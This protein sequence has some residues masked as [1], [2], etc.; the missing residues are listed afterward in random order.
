MKS[1]FSQFLKSSLFNYAQRLV[2]VCVYLL[3][4]NANANAWSED[5]YAKISVSI[6]G[7]GVVY[8]KGPKDNEYKSLG[9]DGT[10][11]LKY[12]DSGMS[13]SAPDSKSI[14]YELKA[15]PIDDT[16]FFESWE[17]LGAANPI[18]L[19]VTGKTIENPTDI[20]S[21]I[22]AIFKKK[23]IHRDY[24]KVV[25]IYLDADGKVVYTGD[26]ANPSSIQFT[27]GGGYVNIGAVVGTTTYT[28]FTSGDDTIVY[29]NAS[30]HP[31]F[32]IYYA[33]A[34]PNYAFAG[35]Y[36]ETT[37]MAQLKANLGKLDLKNPTGK[38]NS[39]AADNEY[40]QKNT[41]ECP[42]DAALA[43]VAPTMYAVFR[44]DM[45]YYYTGPTAYVSAHE[46]D[47]GLV[48]VDRGD[49][50]SIAGVPAESWTTE[51]V[52]ETQYNQKNDKYSFVYYAKPNPKYAF[53]GW[54]TTQFGS[55]T[56]GNELPNEPY[57][58]PY[59][60]SDENANPE[61]PFITRAL[62][63]VFE[64]FYYKK[65]AAMLASNS[66]DAGYIYVS[67]T[68]EAMPEDWTED[69]Q[70]V[71]DEL[72]QVAANGEEYS[73]KVYYHARPK[74]G[75]TFSGWSSTSDGL[76]IVSQSADY[77]ET[78]TTQ[79]TDRAYPHVAAPLYAVFRSD[80]DIRQQ[81]RMIVYQDAEGNRSINDAKILVD[82]QKAAT[83]TATLSGDNVSDFILSNR[84]GSKTGQSITF[85]ATQGLIEM[86]LSYR[87]NLNEAVGKSVVVT[88][89]NAQLGI[90]RR[91][92][93]VVEE[94]PLITFLPTDG[95]GTYTVR[96][97]NG[98]G[99]NYI[100]NADDR[101]NLD[102]AVTHESMSNI[103]INLT[104]DVASDNYYFFGWEMIDGESRTYISHDALCTYQFT[105]SVKIRPDFI[106]NNRATFF[107]LS[108][109]DNPDKTLYHDL[110]KALNAAQQNLSLGGEQVVVLN[111]QNG[112]GTEVVLPKGNYEIPQGVILLIPGDATYTNK[113][114]LD[115]N[116]YE[117]AKNPGKNDLHNSRYYIKLNVEDGTK[118]TV[119]GGLNVYA[120]LQ[121]NGQTWLGR[122]W[123][124]GWID[125]GDN[126]TIDVESSA[127]LSVYGYITGPLSNAITIKPGATVRESFQIRDWH[128]GT[129]T[130][131]YVTG[132]STY[133]VF[134]ASQFY[135][136][137]IEVPLTLESG[138]NEELMAA[139]NIGA[140]SVVK[141]PFV[142]LQDGL[143]HLNTGTKLTK[144]YD[145]Y[146]DSQVYIME[147]SGATTQVELGKI[148]LQDVA[149][150]MPIIGTIKQDI[151]SS[152]YVLPLPHNMDITVKNAKLLVSYDFAFLAGSKLTID[153]TATVVLN[154][155]SSQA[156]N[157][158]VYDRA[159]NGN[160]FGISNSQLIPVGYRPTTT[161]NV[162][163]DNG[164]LYNRN[165]DA[166]QDASVV[167]DGLITCGQYGY[168][169]TTN[170]ANEV[171]HCA[172][173]TSNGGGKITFAALGTKS[174]TYQ[175]PMGSW[176]EIPVTPARMRNADG[177]YVA[178][179]AST[180]YTYAQN[181]WQTGDITGTHAAPTVAD[182]TPKFNVVVATIANTYVGKST[183]VDITIETQN[184]TIT[185]ADV[186]WTK[187]ISG[188]DA[189]Q[190]SLVENDSKIS[191]SPK[192]EGTKQVTLTLTATYTRY[193]DTNNPA[194]KY[195]YSKNIT[196]A[197][198][199][200]YLNANILAFE[201]L[202]SLY[203]GQEAIA[204][205]KDGN[206]SQPITIETSSAGIVT[207]S[208][209]T[210]AATL[211][212]TAVGEVT[213]TAIQ[214]A[215]LE[216]NIA[217]T[218]I[219]KRVK[220]TDPV[221]WNWD[222][223]YFGTVN[224]NPVTVLNG[225]S[226]W[227]LTEKE[228]T[229]NIIDFKTNPY[230]ATIAD[231][232]AGKYEV[233]FE[234]TNGTITKEFKS[235]V[236]VNPQHLRVDVNKDTVFHAVTLSANES[237]SFDNDNK[238]V[239][240]QSTEQSISQ[241]KMTFIGVPDKLYFI[242]VGENTWQIEEST[243]GVN[244][245]T[246]FPWKYLTANEPFEM[247]LLPS[248]KYVRISYGA[249][250]TTAALLK[251]LYIT[252]LEDVKADVKKIYMPID[253]KNN[254]VKEV[255]LT[256]AN[257]GR[258]DIRTNDASKFKIKFSDSNSE[259][260]DV[261]SI[262]ATTDEN[263][264]GIKG[265]EVV[266]YATEVTTG[267]LQ[268]YSGSQ[269]V[270]QIPIHAYLFP[271]ELPIKLA[272]DEP[273]GG[274]RYYYVTTHSH[275]VEWDGT[276]GVRKITMHNAVS[277]AA[278][279]VTF[280][281]EG[282]PTFISFD[283]TAAAKGT[284]VIEQSTDGKNWNTAV[285]ATGDVM[286]NGKLL[287]TVGSTSKYIRVIYESAY[288]EKVEITDLTIVGSA[289]V[290]VNPTKLQLDANEVD[291]ITLTAVNLTNVKIEP[292]G[293]F[294]VCL[295]EGGDYAGELS[296]T[297][298]NGLSANGIAY[299]TLYVK[300][301]GESLPMVEY[302]DIVITNTAEGA[303][304][305][306]LATVELVGIKGSITSGSLGINTGVPSGYT[307]KGTFEGSGY[308]NVNIS[309]AFSAGET[310]TP[311][312]DY[313]VIY[314]ETTTND[315]QSIITTPNKNAGSNAKT[316]YYIYKK[317]SAGSAYEL[318]KLVENANSANKAWSEAGDD[319]VRVVANNAVSMYI[320]GFC[321][322]ATT[323]YTKADEGVWYFRANGGQSIDVYLQDCYIYSRA[324]TFDGH[325]FADRQDGNSFVDAYVCGSG[326]VL[327]FACNNKDNET[328]MNVTI[329]TL[330]NNLLKSNYG[331]FFQSIAGRAFQASSPVQ[332]RLI[333]DTYWAATKT[334]LNF[335]DVWPASQ[336][337]KTGVRTN[338]FISL[339]KQVN[340]APSIDMGAPNTVVNFN[341]GQVE[342]QNAQIVSHNYKSSLAICPRSGE[343]A[344]I[345][346]SYGMATDATSGTV[347]FNDGTTTVQPMWVSPDYF[348]SY[349]CD[350]DEAGNYIRNAKGEY[351]T[352]CLRTPENTFVYGG[353]H[354]MMR[355][356]P[357][358]EAQGGAP[359]DKPGEDGKLL[360][361]YKYPKKPESGKKGG[362]SDNG[363]NGLV[364]PTEGN[365]PEGYNVNS[366]TPNNN[367]T[368]DDADDYLNFW[369]DPTFEPAAQ[370]EINKKIS[371]WKTC[372]TE[373]A[374]EYAGYGGSVGG[375]TYVEFANGTQTEIV[376]NL[377]Y[378]QLDGNILEV[379]QDP[380]YSAP[381]KNP[382]PEGDSYLP[383]KPSRVGED[384]QHYITTT[385]QY[386]VENRIYYITTATAD[387]WM[388]F[389]AP[390]DVENIYIVET[391]S[392][393][394]LERT[395]I[396]TNANGEELTRRQSILLEQAKHN[397]DFASFFAV[398]I[399]L[400][401][402]KS[403]ETIYREW[404]EWGKMVDKEAGLYTSGEYNIR[405]KWQLTPYLG[406]NWQ[407][408]NFYLNHNSADWTLVKDIEGNDSIDV[409]WIIPTIGDD[410]VLLRRGE[411]YS[412]LFPYC[413]GCVEKDADEEEIE[414][415][416]WDYWTGKILIFES[417]EGTLNDP[418]IIFG[419][420]DLDVS[421]ITISEDKY[422]VVTGNYTFAKIE[423][424]TTEDH[425]IEV[426]Y[427]VPNINSEGFFPVGEGNIN[428]TNSFVVGPK[429]TTFGAR[430]RSFS[431]MG[432][433]NYVSDEDNSGDDT[434]TGEHIPTVGGGSDIFVTSVAGGINIAVSEPQYVGVFSVNG[435]LLYNGWV[436]TA[437]N[438]NLVNR[439][440]Y[441]VVGEN[442]S[443]KVVY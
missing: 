370:P 362:W 330:D 208:G 131:S 388:T 412:M 271:Q 195:T 68:N 423:S 413:V 99:V 224:D 181:K 374:A 442:N 89:S 98:S 10:Y 17:G 163:K 147:G 396:K 335:T 101:K 329:H 273:A 106:P 72:Q 117:T 341:G 51:Y 91:I 122:P 429:L 377:L 435:A 405:G 369:F 250:N 20:A 272:T 251:E 86:A 267:E 8:A 136:Q 164:M 220:V 302:G 252:K 165:A 240:F 218:T 389:T 65:P 261:L 24:A 233:K 230:T 231:Q 368:K 317:N 66:Q 120:R 371:Y 342:L 180:T 130:I 415:T 383:V 110:Q 141:A 305:A 134:P 284:W 372:M 299:I 43:P 427:Y 138:A 79:I 392:E 44:P 239:Q 428:P 192:S 264:F 107:L 145:K 379:I 223:L 87:G 197:A 265:I 308:R 42:A 400:G 48:Y 337:S 295:T 175:R 47:G 155:T 312:F 373:I 306:V 407:S 314:G 128:G 290:S 402:N 54:A 283:Y 417:R 81:D 76:N 331:C 14:S 365:V 15:E 123:R 11:V 161:Y 149:V 190:F 332:I 67:L 326:A 174:K 361:L 35:W 129:E 246:S 212:P 88:F 381:V 438:V 167:V 139:V 338:G 137:N 114:I 291:V 263:P 70:P 105:K 276:D 278:P 307:L 300:W 382:A 29:H 227:T 414:R 202:S 176:L 397:A 386:Q 351:L 32:Y 321:P 94:A 170:T 228:D 349:L 103:E 166:L 205:F 150:D 25:A 356:C 303:N 59:E 75:N 57:S 193:V 151:S 393:S 34:A 225:P 320:T 28:E 126:C 247:S 399:A 182:Y 281:F 336:N 364:T 355:A 210:S 409:N 214:P 282:A 259:P 274:D 410:G 440:V 58:L 348:E 289:S 390:F 133:R 319:A 257:T 275:N 189:D 421:G 121:I 78:Y 74:S 270:L 309:A 173:I 248:T 191:F 113:A 391:Y 102:V 38:P 12:A 146:T 215:D 37:L 418:H 395:A 229:K 315:G 184:N 387:T 152:D 26:L 436:E 39:N 97:T 33:K 425:D 298:G 45:T 92:S 287:R 316:P 258:L 294:K 207:T 327:V 154:G 324:K 325:T 353:S 159:Q 3:F 350:K 49:A 385:E 119:R 323:G 347:N 297:T 62:Y 360:G 346:L 311:L 178:P 115:E 366:V 401:Q 140:I 357:D 183:S 198:S 80:I 156:A 345:R 90:S 286:A 432:K 430:I 358:P 439:G 63:A 384:L 85:D 406:S 196:I 77:V 194:V 158:F 380:S 367:G 46:P 217:G 254:A 280:A 420:D 279:Y 343:F 30:S 201:D 328:S 424:P 426:Y 249:G 19:S 204:L 237:V 301:T 313:V 4:Y 83:L 234:F 61:N 2:I 378:C 104:E 1:K 73:Y 16:Y 157:M 235:V 135:I 226:D 100:V 153:K 260:N 376:K 441:V 304:N 422:A 56:Y 177:T 236:I 142:D 434:P 21:T 285:P 404:I 310:P 222:I 296:L 262:P 60:M 209:N 148:L 339:Q 292:N 359:K 172:N 6:T 162:T 179:T 186:E 318:E 143:F 5:Y 41:S 333:D 40:T 375:D 256:Y 216:N 64:S 213:I 293:N 9:E 82:F 127:S 245:T 144:Y 53:K 241:W 55:A 242:P 352:T 7:E 109:K 185:W 277:D 22:N 27:Q 132:Q 112:M 334:T 116:D 160:Y 403:F 255:V 394:E 118:I 243:N 169:Y 52:D 253:G 238:A 211:T 398:T 322:Y 408:A 419:S 266:C 206:N 203:V 108:E 13:G 96:M 188:V 50:G 219:T 433:I 171:T 221:V 18:T 23:T 95:K 168:L 31:W 411:T 124:Y 437:V 36:D 340:N 269:L 416:Y 71:A 288:A 125:L 244:W 187:T 363:T 199:A 111:D 431:R 354:C 84:S 69:E 232:I 344:G 93:I 200:I 268:V 443:V